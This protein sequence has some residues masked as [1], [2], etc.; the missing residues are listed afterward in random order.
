[1]KNIPTILTIFGATGDLMAKK[2][3]PALYS[4][5]KSGELPEHF[6]IIGSGRRDFNG[7]KFYEL[8]GENIHKYLKIDDIDSNFYNLCEYHQGDLDDKES[9]ARLKQKLLEIDKSFGLESNKIF[10]FSIAPEFYAKASDNIA[11]MNLNNE[12]VKLIVEKPFGHDAK[13]AEELIV[14]MKQYFNENQI[15]I[16]DHY[17][18]KE[19]VQD[20]LKFRFEDGLYENIWNKENIKKIE[21]TGLEDFGVEKRGS[22]YE[23]VGALKDY[24]QNHLLVM[25]SLLTM[26]KPENDVRAKRAEI[27]QK[28]KVFNGDEVR[29]YTFRAQYRGYRD[30][31]NV[32]PNSQIETYFRSV[33]FLN[34]ERWNSVP[35]VIDTGKRLEKSTKQ[36]IIHFDDFK[37]IFA[38]FPKQYISKIDKNGKEEL[39][40]TFAE[41]KVQYVDEYASLITEAIE[42]KMENFASIEEVISQWKYV[43]PIINSWKKNLVPLEFYKPNTNDILKLAYERIDRNLEKSKVLL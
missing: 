5:Y 2:I 37:I 22:F 25:L 36:I 8:L 13:S 34:D 42:G 24:G 17:L 3:T 6:Q 1:M 30:I 38:I 28:I 31:E 15:Y 21:L 27:I 16:I 7:N 4:L 14:Q 35:I 39:I 9:Y 20:I 43:D 40:K 23:A 11:A 18:G 29:K 19:V 33:A 41:H 32:D 26:N 12:K 10:Y